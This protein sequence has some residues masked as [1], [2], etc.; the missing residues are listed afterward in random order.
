MIVPLAML[1]LASIRG[2]QGPNPDVNRL[3]QTWNSQCATNPD[4]PT[5]RQ[6][7]ILLERTLYRGL[8][9]QYLT[10]ER[11]DRPLL[12]AAARAETP[13]L[14]AFGLRRLADAP[15]AED[16]VA[17]AE[18]LDSPFPAVRSAAAELA[19]GLENH[20]LK[21]LA[22]RIAHRSA[23]KGT[24][25]IAEEPPGTKTLGAAPYPGARFR[26]AAS[27][28]G[29]A[30]FTTNDA[31]DKVLAFYA[32]GRKTL[33]AE[34]LKARRK[35]KP[36]KGDEQAMV[37][38]MMAELMKGKD[39]QQVAQE[40]GQSEQGRQTDWGKGIEGEAG[41]VAPRFIVLAETGPQ[42]I[43]TQVLVVYRDEAFGS[44]AIA[45]RS[46]PVVPGLVPTRTQKDVD[47]TMAL[48]ELRSR[49]D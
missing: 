21:L 46:T 13:E 15:R 20:G 23:I 24:G 36:S 2:G 43:P 11:I 12:Q 1:M 17:A 47:F 41:I 4:S 32:K 33:T 44:T 34:E 8:T 16:A 37:Q 22:N 27:Q 45:F 9:R 3:L 25:L 26:F 49:V 5:C 14:A 48:Y 19:H 6:T 39:P 30:V 29:M 38:L 28:P 42:R 35:E 18:G 40:L 10:G 31:P 7:R